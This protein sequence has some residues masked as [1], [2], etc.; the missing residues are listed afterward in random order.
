MPKQKG[1]IP[2]T[3]TVKNTTYFSLN[4]QYYER[5]KSSLTAAVV[6]TDPAFAASRRCNTVFATAV[7][8]ARTIYPQLPTHKR[9]AG[10]FGQ[11][12]GRVYQMVLKG[13]DADS[14]VTAILG[15]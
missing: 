13:M 4:G 5:R 2:I 12:T 15:E 7:A 3:G 11:L 9:I 6:A 14:I 1:P 10:A 8:I